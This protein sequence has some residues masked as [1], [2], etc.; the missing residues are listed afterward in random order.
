MVL[1]VQV[2]HFNFKQ[3]KILLEQN[4]HTKHILDGQDRMKMETDINAKAKEEK[5][6]LEAEALAKAKEDDEDEKENER[7]IVNMPDQL[8][9]AKNQIKKLKEE[10]LDAEAS[11]KA[12]AEAKEKKRVEQENQEKLKF[13]ERLMEKSQS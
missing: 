10:K 6:K 5:K 3:N 8:S 4:N 12:D 13:D 11:A 9:E 7:N 1:D 2:T